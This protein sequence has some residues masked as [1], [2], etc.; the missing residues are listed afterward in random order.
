MLAEEVFGGEAFVYHGSWMRPDK[1][2]PIFFNNQFKPGSGAGSMYGN[3][4]YTVYYLEDTQTLDGRYGD[5]IY[6]FKINLHGF[7]IF[8]LHIAKLVYKKLLMPSEQAKLLRLDE[9]II[10]NLANLESNFKE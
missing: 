1:F 8:D 2:I 6:R 3:G 7:I 4:L 10:K 5:Y 9:K